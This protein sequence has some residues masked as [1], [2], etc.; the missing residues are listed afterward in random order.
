MKN[1]KLITMKTLFYFE[2]IKNFLVFFFRIET[3]T[4]FFRK[5]SVSI[6]SAMVFAYQPKKKCVHGF[7]LGW[8]PCVF[9]SSTTNVA[10]SNRMQ[11]LSFAMRSDFPIFTA[12]LNLSVKIYNIMIADFLPAFFLVPTVNV[13]RFI[14]SA[15]WR[16]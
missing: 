16:V 3:R 6:Y 8:C 13:C 10:N 2:R 7:F 4:F 15:S 12:F 11:V 1:Y 9:S 5:I 14:V